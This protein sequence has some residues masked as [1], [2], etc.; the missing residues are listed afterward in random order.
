MSYSKEKLLESLIK[1]K[2]EYGYYPTR[3]DFRAKR[4]TPSKNVFYRLFG[5]T[6]NAFKQAEAYEKGEL[7]IEEEKKRKV[8]RPIKEK[9]G[10]CCPFCGNYTNNAEEYYSSLET[11]LTIR[12]LD[13]LKSSNGQ[14]YFE[15]V[16][17]CIYA[18]FGLENSTVRQELRS[19]GYL[20]QFDQRHGEN[21]ETNSYRNI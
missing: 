5:S 9:G 7:V 8:K 21:G 20:E 6:E 3:K 1:F 15:G 10:F 4:I 18:V 2:D 11:I 16:M 14:G 12:F 17:D 13:L 19:A